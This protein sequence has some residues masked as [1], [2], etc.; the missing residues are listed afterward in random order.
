MPF[1]ALTGAL[2]LCRDIGCDGFNL[3]TLPAR[4][5]NARRDFGGLIR[6]LRAA[7]PSLILQPELSGTPGT[8]PFLSSGWL[9]TNKPNHS[10][11]EPLYLQVPA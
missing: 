8:L 11:L 2:K 9:Y 1:L 5:R 10:I 6:D 7:A 4:S 3:D